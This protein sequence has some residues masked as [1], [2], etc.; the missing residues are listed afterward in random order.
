M[1][2]MSVNTVLGLLKRSTC[3][4]GRTHSVVYCYLPVWCDAEPQSRGVLLWLVNVI[5]WR[6][7]HSYQ[8]YNTHES[9][10]R[11]KTSRFIFAKTVI[12]RLE[13]SLACS[14]SQMSNPHK[15]PLPA[16]SRPTA[17]FV[18]TS[19]STEFG[20][21]SA[22]R[23]AAPLDVSWATQNNLF[24]GGWTIDYDLVWYGL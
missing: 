13:P 23:P 3:V 22:D 21:R 20:V 10:T 24:T 15:R 6:S 12:S 11:C 7:V 1:V 18:K 17:L 9:V 16:Y 8:S 2:L 4:R 5:V 19:Q 14:A